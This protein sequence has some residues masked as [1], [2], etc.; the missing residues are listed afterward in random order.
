MNRIGNRRNI[1]TFLQISLASAFLFIGTEARADCEEA[2]CEIVVEAPRHYYVD[3]QINR[4]SS[5][6]A[7]SSWWEST[8]Q[9]VSNY[10]QDFLDQLITLPVVAPADSLECALAQ[11]QLSQQAEAAKQSGH[12]IIILGED[13]FDPD[14]GLDSNARHYQAFLRNIFAG[15]AGGCVTF[16][17]AT[18]VELPNDYQALV[19]FAQSLGLATHYIDTASYTNSNFADLSVVNSRDVSM[20]QNLSSL[21]GQCSLTVAINGIKHLDHTE[22][23]RAGRVNMKDLLGNSA[24]VLDARAAEQACQ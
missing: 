7:W 17:S 19:T 16:E 15:S 5:G 6:W 21:T 3:V 8:N 4:D 23:P 20:A 2:S 12:Q 10:L 18:Y 13:H 9:Y 11:N 14:T 1:W 22:D 24:V